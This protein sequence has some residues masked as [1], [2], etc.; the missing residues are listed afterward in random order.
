MSKQIAKMFFS[1]RSKILT[2]NQLIGTE[3]NKKENSKSFRWLWEVS[4]DYKCMSCV[5]ANQQY[6]SINESE[7][8]VAGENTPCVYE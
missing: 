2:E 8:K 3:L 4:V 6:E 7:A 5:S 1:C